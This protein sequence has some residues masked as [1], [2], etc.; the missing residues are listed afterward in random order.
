MGKRF[1]KVMREEHGIGGS[2]Y[3]GDQTQVGSLEWAPEPGGYLG[4]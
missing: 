3:L 1:W 2:N 4:A